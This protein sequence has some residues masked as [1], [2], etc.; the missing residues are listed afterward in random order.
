MKSLGQ[1][2][3][4]VGALGFLGAL[5]FMPTSIPSVDGVEVTN[6]A[7][8]QRQALVTIGFA[9]LFLAGVVVLSADQV[10]QALTR[11]PDHPVDDRE[12]EALGISRGPNGYSVG[13]FS[14]WSAEDAVRAAKRENR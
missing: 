9:V 7:L 3:V 6:L 10:V 14:Y 11:E 2:L 12:L 8:Q 4:A 13:G 5:F 1:S